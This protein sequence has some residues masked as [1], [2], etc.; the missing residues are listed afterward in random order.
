MGSTVTLQFIGD[1]SKRCLSLT[2][3][4]FVEQSLRCAAIAPRLDEGV[5]HVAVLSHG[6]PEILPLTVDRDED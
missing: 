1:Q 5:D 3:Q 2:I 6:T 4:E